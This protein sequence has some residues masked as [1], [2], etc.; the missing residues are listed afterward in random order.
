MESSIWQ[1]SSEFPRLPERSASSPMDHN[2]TKNNEG[3]PD[4]DMLI[5]E[6]L[7]RERPTLYLG[8][9]PRW[10]WNDNDPARKRLLARLREL[11]PAMDQAHI[12]DWKPLDTLTFSP[13]ISILAGV[14]QSRLE[15]VLNHLDSERSREGLVV[16]LHDNESRLSACHS[17][18]IRESSRFE[19]LLDQIETALRERK[20]IP[21]GETQEGKVH[22]EHL[23]NKAS[24]T[25]SDWSWDE[26]KAVNIPE[27]FRH[28]LA[29]GLDENAE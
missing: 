5:R 7:T 8:S 14:P 6:I 21:W 23:R 19:A 1:E 29:A 9:S 11:V 25:R 3:K 18:D 10:G 24:T 20:L 4:T 28:E 13:G 2:D 17:F 27:E 16:V 26:T 15:A 12:P 22:I